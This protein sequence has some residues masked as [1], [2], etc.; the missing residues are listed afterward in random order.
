MNAVAASDPQHPSLFSILRNRNFALLWSGQA[1]SQIGDGLFNVAMMWLVLQLTGSAMAMGT[2]VI[3]TQLPRLAFQLIGG[4]SV[5]RYDRR[6]L[7]LASDAIRGI[8]M[9]VFAILVATNQIQMIHIYILSMVFGIVGAFFFPATSA[10]VPN[11][12]QK[13]ALVPANSLLSLTQQGSQIF[14]PALAGILIAIPAIGIAGVSFM[15]AASFAVGILGL[16]LMRLPAYLNGARKT[17]NSFWVE[18]G[19]GVR[20]LFRFRVLVIIVFLAMALN[21]ALAPASIV[22][23]IFAKNNLGVGPEGFGTLMS[24]LAVG[25]VLGSIMIGMRPP[26]SQRGIV[27]F[28]LTAVE[29]IIFATLGLVPIFIVSCI[30]AFLM[31]F[32]NGIVNTILGAML[33]SLI[34][35]EYRGR[36]FS[37]T[38]MIAMGLMPISLAIAGGLTDTVG[39]SVVFIVGGAICLVASLFGLTFREI[40]ELQ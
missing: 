31:G 36:V 15:N 25:M 34:A 10:L 18:V 30:L 28:L 40:R 1:I 12:V 13:D 14:G 4:V 7:M 22:V 6:M 11:I 16:L 24:T 32:A 5:D 3:L 33:Q 2:T 38:S 35:D 17:N 39:A 19:D 29:G 21:F 26:R 9:L 8:V 20:Y 27:V 23:P 37:L